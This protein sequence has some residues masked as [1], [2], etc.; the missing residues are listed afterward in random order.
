M[1]S[2][3]VK[4]PM[5]RISLALMAL[6]LA[7][8]L[9]VAPAAGT[10][11]KAPTRGGTV[12]IGVPAQL[13]P[14]CFNV[15]T[16]ACYSGIGG[17]VDRLIFARPFAY[18]PGGTLRPG[19]VSR[20]TVTK[21]PV[22]ITFH[23]RPEARWSDGRPVTAFDLRFH[24]K[25]A[26]ASEVLRTFDPSKEG[27]IWK[28]TRWRALD[29][30]RFRLWLSEPVSLPLLKDFYGAGPRPRHVISTVDLSGP[31][32]WR[33]TVVDPKTGRPIGSG[34]FLMQSHKRGQSI[35]L[36]R[37]RSYWGPHTSYLDKLVFRFLPVDELADALRRSEIDVILPQQN[38]EPAVQE[39]RRRR[40]PGIRVDAAPTVRVETLNMRVGAG[41]NPALGMKKVRQALAYGIDRAG[42]VRTLG[43]GVFGRTAQPVAP[44]QSMVHLAQAPSYQPNWQRYRYRPALARRLL[45]QAGCRP[46][47]DGIRVC[48]GERLSLRIGALTDIESR[49]QTIAFLQENLR[50]IGVELKPQYFSVDAG[51]LADALMGGSLDLAIW[52]WVFDIGGG[53]PIPRCKDSS[54]FSGYCSR[55]YDREFDS[56]E[57]T[58]DDDAREAA[59]NRVDR[60]LADAV[61]VLPLYQ[62]TGQVAH[63]TN[64]HL[65]NLD[66][67]F[68]T[69]NAEDWWLEPDA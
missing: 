21:K 41:G 37:N 35:T 27:W 63:R 31:D 51:Q 64:L 3:K 28:V 29:A 6:V 11:Q 16:S 53:S 12:V 48:G 18:A 23:L 22:T 61:P 46:G 68:P 49:K 69:W 54:N 5:T 2:R 24:L 39:I 10:P 40:P 14:S 66:G 26:R 55:L 42:L 4:A 52:A 65:P 9:A 7:G 38:T 1:L 32:F 15:F 67:I 50:A 47:A 57:G 58:L 8:V 25:A 62:H 43:R 59:L 20:V 60:L 45:D 44:A 36:V 30:K 34:P 19:L 33:D 56:A 13:E 17:V